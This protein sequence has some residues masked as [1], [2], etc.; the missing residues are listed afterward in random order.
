MGAA[1]NQQSPGYLIN[2]AELRGYRFFPKKTRCAPF[3]IGIGVL[4]YKT[5]IGQSFRVQN[6][7]ANPSWRI[8][9]SIQP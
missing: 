3:P 8:P 9:Q 4:D 2:V 6:R 5:P 7:A 1:R